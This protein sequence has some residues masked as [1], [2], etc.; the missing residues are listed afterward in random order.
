MLLYYLIIN[1]IIEISELYI[2]VYCIISLLSTF[3]MWKTNTITLPYSSNV[4]KTEYIPK[5]EKNTIII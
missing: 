1:S 4:L 2:H 3:E 5:T